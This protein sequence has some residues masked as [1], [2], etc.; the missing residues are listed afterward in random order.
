[1]IPQLLDHCNNFTC[2]LVC[3]LK[4]T[5]SRLRWAVASGICM[6]DMLSQ[7]PHETTAAS[8]GCT[9]QQMH[10]QPSCQNCSSRTSCHVVHDILLHYVC[11]IQARRGSLVT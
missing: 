1:M 4:D 7:Q 6:S 2:I 11:G 8:G 3:M 5:T 10:Y 9:L